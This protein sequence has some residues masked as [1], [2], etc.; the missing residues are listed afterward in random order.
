MLII[1]PW[2]DLGAASIRIPTLLNPPVKNRCQLSSSQTL[3]PG[4]TSVRPQVPADIVPLRLHRPLRSR[5]YPDPP[6][7]VSIR[8]LQLWVSGDENAVLQ[9][10]STEYRTE[11]GS[12]GATWT[13]LLGA[14]NVGLYWRYSITQTQTLERLRSDRPT[15]ASTLPHRQRGVFVITALFFCGAHPEASRLFIA[16]VG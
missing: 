5:R 3:S 7:L 4:L 6:N 15:T 9:A 13:G 10:K 8:K 14:A 1:G 16:L 2:V 11:S 12:T